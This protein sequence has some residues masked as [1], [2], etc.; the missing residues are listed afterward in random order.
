MASS[1]NEEY[2]TEDS[3]RRLAGKIRAYW[4][5]EGFQGIR[6][7]ARQT[8]QHPDA[9]FHIRSNIGRNGFPPGGRSEPVEPLRHKVYR[10]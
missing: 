8:V 4:I 3:A 6:V 10:L 5:A 2:S 7:E 9:H 1:L